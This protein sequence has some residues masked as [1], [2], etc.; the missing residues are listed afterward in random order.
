[1]KYK[2]ILLRESP[3]EYL[4]A[5]HQ[6]S[7]ERVARWTAKREEAEAKRPI[8]THWLYTLSIYPPVILVGYLMWRCVR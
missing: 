2:N 8:L 1:M 4:E 5:K 3:I 7:K 6:R